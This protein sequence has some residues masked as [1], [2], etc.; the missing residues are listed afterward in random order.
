MR[1]VAIAIVILAASVTG[2]VEAAG[3]NATP[4]RSKVAIT[5]ISTDV[6]GGKVTAKGKGV[7]P[8]VKRLCQRKRQVIVFEEATPQDFLVA[9]DLTNKKGRWSATP[10]AGSY[11]GVPHHAI[12]VAK[13]V[14]DRKTERKFRCKGGTSA[15][16]T[17]SPTSP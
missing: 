10:T 12:V 6:A 1:R 14:R 13:T 2:I 17:P 11:L 7:P 9:R 3:P 15:S 4:V 16:V 5:T 8:R